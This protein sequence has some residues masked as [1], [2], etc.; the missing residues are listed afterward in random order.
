MIVLG[1]ETSCDETSASVFINDKIV[2]N[3]TYTQLI[4]SKYGGV[5]P[6]FASR[7][8]EKIISLIIY[9]ALQKANVK[10][11]D[12]NCIG[13]TYGPGLM[14]ALLVGVNFVKGMSI[15]LGIPF[16]GINHLEGHIFA[17]FIDY[18]NI[19]FPFLCLLV[20]GGHTQIW[21]VKNYQNYNLI[22]TTRDDAAGEAF[23][24][25]AKILSLGYPGGPE[26][27]KV[28]KLGD[29]NKYKFTIPSIKNSEYDFSFS[30]LK[31]ALLYK[32]NKMNKKEQEL[33]RSNLAASYQKAI[34]L[35]LLNKI[36]KCIKNT[37]I[38]TVTIA[39]GVAANS[40]LREKAKKIEDKNEVKFLFPS[41]EYCTDNGAM[42]AITASYYLKNK[43]FSNLELSPVPNLNIE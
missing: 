5:V 6:E 30:G 1:I 24:K 36:E 38:K 42:I 43:I 39:G 23:D 40:Y 14:G 26:I 33:E 7:E 35:S 13:V 25:G 18:P 31:T 3:Q 20:S 4:H 27:D 17:N 11:S 15:A 41:F 21:N 2:S 34:I 12:I 9:K 16:I 19:E 28:A 32:H 29:P 37:K 10:T 8:H 22:S